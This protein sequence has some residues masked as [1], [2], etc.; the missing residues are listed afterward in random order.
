[1]QFYVS[2]IKGFIL[3]WRMQEL[4]QSVP[5]TATAYSHFY[6]RQCRHCYLLSAH[7]VLISPIFTCAT[8][9]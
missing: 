5:R 6:H 2:A 8:L 3:D 9:C 4:A 1:L 7:G